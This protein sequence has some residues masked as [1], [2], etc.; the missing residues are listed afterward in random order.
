[1]DIGGLFSMVTVAVGTAALE[2][3]VTRPSSVPVAFWATAIEDN[4]HKAMK[5]LVALNKE[6]LFSVHTDP[7]VP[8]AATPV[9]KNCQL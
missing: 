1:M 7:A 6:F 2:G 8:S 3:S 5:K 4:R 9:R